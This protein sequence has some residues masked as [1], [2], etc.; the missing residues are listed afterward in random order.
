VGGVFRRPAHEI[1]NGVVF[2]MLT[3]EAKNS[4]DVMPLGFD[5]KDPVSWKFSYAAPQ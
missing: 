5:V 2:V 1:V 3:S 4:Y